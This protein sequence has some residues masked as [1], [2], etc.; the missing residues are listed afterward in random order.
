MNEKRGKRQ[1]SFGKHR[2]RTCSRLE[3]ELLPK[4]QLIKQIVSPCFDFPLHLESSW[5]KEPAPTCD[6]HHLVMGISSVQL[7]DF[8]SQSESY[9]MIHTDDR[10]SHRR[11]RTP[12]K[13]SDVDPTSRKLGGVNVRQKR[14]GSPPKTGHH[15][16][17]HRMTS[18]R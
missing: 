2:T 14:P 12:P 3:V 4:Y 15:K 7:F 11:A 8:R 13:R 16:A 9:T 18:P 5:C 6:L 10:D 17:D 1:K